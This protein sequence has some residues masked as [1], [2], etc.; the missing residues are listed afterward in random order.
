VVPKITKPGSFE[1]ISPPERYLQFLPDVLGTSF[2][3][4]R[5]SQTHP[6]CNRGVRWMVAQE[7][8][9]IGSDK[10]VCFEKTKRSFVCSSD[11]EGKDTFL[12]VLKP[13]LT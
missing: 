8:L 2:A 10:V 5:G 9:R 13:N 3:I 11:R 12:M 4:Y 1:L 7:N 6:P